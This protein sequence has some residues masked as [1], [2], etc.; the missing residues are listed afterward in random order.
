MRHRGPVVSRPVRTATCPT[1]KA[2]VWQGYDADRC[3]VLVTVDHPPVDNLGEAVALLTGRRTFDLVPC[4][5]SRGGVI[6]SELVERTAL[7]ISRPTPVRRPVHAEHRCDQ[8]LPTTPTPVT[9]RGWA[10]GSEF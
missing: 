7:S 10:T 2:K 6:G 5:G 3:G 4:R 9:S 1:C 8:P